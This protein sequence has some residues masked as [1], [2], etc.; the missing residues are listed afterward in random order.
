M[1]TWNVPISA[2]MGLMETGRSNVQK[3]CPYCLQV[4][5][6]CIKWLVDH[7]PLKMFSHV[8]AIKGSPKA[9]DGEW[10]RGRFLVKGTSSRI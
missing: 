5:P 6:A 4:L 3:I 1:V 10:G 2:A 8:F 9:V 7:S